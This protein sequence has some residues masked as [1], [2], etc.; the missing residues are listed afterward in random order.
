MFIG[1]L[2]DGHYTSYH[3][4]DP[5][6]YG[7]REEL[8]LAKANIQ[9][10][11]KAFPEATVCLGNHDVHAARKAMDNNI[12]AAWI[13][14]FGE[15]LGTPNWKFT[16]ELIFNGIRYTHG[17]KLSGQNAAYNQAIHRQIST[18]IGHIHTESNIRYVRDKI[19]G[20]I[21]GCGIDRDAYAFNY[22]K[23]FHKPIQIGCGVVLDDTPILIKM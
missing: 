8:Q 18:V 4:T 10:W 15:V 1:D 13:K 7:G 23:E 14:G 21:V 16:N 9:E 22:S 20:M 3:G 11:Y 12:P 17:T 19:F 5:D 6:G 2:I